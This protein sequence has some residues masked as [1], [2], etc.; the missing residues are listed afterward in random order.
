MLEQTS[1]SV[2]TLCPLP[3][4]HLEATQLGEIRP[5]CMWEGEPLGKVEEFGKQDFQNHPT[6]KEVRCQ[7]IA[8]KKPVGC[9]KCFLME[10]TGGQSPRTWEKSIQ[11]GCT[12]KCLDA[13]GTVES[14]LLYTN[15]RFNAICN[16]ACRMCGP[17]ASTRWNSEFNK[18]HEGEEGISAANYKTN[19]QEQS[20]AI[21]EELSRPLS[22][23]TKI[24]FAGGEPLL[25]VEHYQLLDSIIELRRTGVQLSYNT[26]ATVLQFGKWNVIEQW[27]KFLDLSRSNK[28]QIALSLDA[29]GPAGEY[30]RYG[31]RWS[32]IEEVVKRL[33]Q[34][35]KIYKDQVD[36]PVC[37]TVSILN[38]YRFPELIRWSISRGIYVG[39]IN[40]FVVSPPWYDLR[41]LPESQKRQIKLV[42]EEQRGESEC[43]D[44]YIDSTISFMQETVPDT[45]WHQKEFYKYTKRLDILRNQNFLDI[46]PEFEVWY[47]F[48]DRRYRKEVL[49]NWIV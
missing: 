49:D 43:L 20:K 47:N 42:L 19:D 12:Y 11:T 46:N 8:G 44:A 2:T 41:I 4:I 3:W 9:S 17:W 14:K 28:L 48:L 38:V 6:L 32:E 30:I 33:V 16:L 24:H 13:T 21:Y 25:N 35:Q 39:P 22:S 34:L 40:N 15:F 29:V 7:M 36:I 1:S 10:K 37:P 23:L 26:N 18:I 5:C 45:K 31:S 27:K